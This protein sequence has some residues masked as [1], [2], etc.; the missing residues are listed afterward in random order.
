VIVSAPAVPSI[1]KV[2]RRRRGSRGSQDFEWRG[3]WG[4]RRIYGPPLG[5]CG[6]ASSSRGGAGARVFGCRGRRGR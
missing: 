6:G 3:R 2:V 5:G 1:V 4:W